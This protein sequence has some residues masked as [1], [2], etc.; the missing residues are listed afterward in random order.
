MTARHAFAAA[1]ALALSLTPCLPSAAQ[2]APYHRYRTLDT[3]HFQVHVA[4]GLEREGRVAAAAA[5]RAYALLARELVTPRGPIDLVVS[6]DADY[7]NGA[8]TTFP[9]NRIVAYAAPPI[10]SGGLRFNDDWLELVVTHELT[11]IFHLDRARG[12]WALGQRVFG[13]APFLFPNAY[14]PSW[15]TE[16][17]AVYYESRLTEGG[18]LHDAESRQLAIA[19]AVERRL[20][21]LDQ[22]SRSTPTFPG[23]AGAYA[24]GSL[25]VDYLASTRGDST[26]GKLVEAQSG[27][28]IPYRL[29]RAAERSFGVSFSEAYAAWRD[30]V[31]RSVGALSPP[32]PGWRELTTHGYYASAPR[33]RSD[34]TL[35]YVG[36]DGRRTNAAWRLTTS[37]AR[38][39][40]G[41]RNGLDANVPL[42]DGGL[43]YAQ[44]EVSDRAEVRS[45]L[46]RAHPDGHEER[47]T[48][49]A[50]LTQPDVRRDGGI[51]AVQLAP[52]RT[53]LVLMGETALGVPR[54][55][56]RARVS[57]A[58]ILVL[59]DA[60]PDETWSEPRWSPD[61]RSVVAVHRRHGGEFFL[62]IV[63]PFGERTTVLDRGRFIISSPSWR[64]N[65]SGVLYL[66]E[67]G[68]APRVWSADANGAARHLAPDSA[69][70]SA[71]S[72]VA[73]ESAPADDAVAGT[74]LR[75]DGFHI[76]VARGAGAR[77]AESSLADSLPITAPVP[78]EALQGGEYRRY[79]PWRSLRPRYWYPLI[80]AAPVR[81]T[82]LGLTTSGEDAIG[83]H[84]YSAYLAVPTSGEGTIGGLFYRYAG[85]RQPVYDVG[86]SQDWS[87][88]GIITDRAGAAVGTLLKRTQDLALA[89]TFVRPRYRRYSS[90]SVGAGLE[91]RLWA[92]EPASVLARLDTSFAR[93]YS[94]PRVFLGGFWSNAQRP[95][96]SI[97]PEDGLSLAFTARERYRAD[98][99]SG[100]ASFSV[101]GTAAG[102]KS[103]DL[104]G[105]AHHVLALRLA[106]GWA[107]RKTGTALEVGGT[108]GTT[109]EIIPGYTVGEGR[110]TFGVRGFE[111]GSV[112]GTRAAAASLEYRAPLVLGARGLK[113]LPFFF[114]RASFTGFADAG[115]ATCA[116][117]PLYTSICAP[118]PFIGRTIASAGAELGIS[119]A[120]LD[121]DS[122]QAIR[123]GIAL[124]V[125][126]RELVGARRATAYLAFGLSY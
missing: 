38:E 6:D 76:G 87:G 107:D 86:F 109:V 74:A 26:V 123:V 59:R 125:V 115:V 25:F 96:L 18:R 100:T 73:V 58:P 13:R 43:L 99:A 17:L 102:Y 92:T 27:Q 105:F 119:A 20:P 14:G 36:T 3:P 60:G 29:D 24:F 34:S 113:L 11:H 15:L 78:E 46:Y 79:S 77:L 47:L 88:Q 23:G 108:S 106:G 122:P 93:Q 40:L 61:G 63:D 19:A 110:R 69:E 111:S 28:L 89:A 66:S 30:S 62:E 98:A 104:P 80:E 2:T 42:A 54:T 97:S 1:I 9:S 83:R 95:L 45:D 112:Y 10:A 48:H 55:V 91:R 85:R 71:T 32:L 116:T 4:E 51:V 120:V 31:E 101:V 44:L 75:A 103:L 82:R 5:E 16:G 68:G 50:R 94:F 117:N 90:V 37:G 65:G 81:G 8:A 126:G 121:W 72:L 33:W 118:A 7:S 21:R 70:G 67:R 22:L 12:I 124:P 64:P 53:R 41:R 84:L 35:V 57:G 52:A 56:V 49:D 114:D 39:R